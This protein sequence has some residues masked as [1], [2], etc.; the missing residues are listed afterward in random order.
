MNES[1]RALLGFLN[2]TFDKRRTGRIGTKFDRT[3]NSLIRERIRF[4]GLF[5]VGFEPVVYDRELRKYRLYSKDDDGRCYRVRCPHCGRLYVPNQWAHMEKHMLRKHG[6][7]NA[8]ARYLDIQVPDET[9]PQS[10]T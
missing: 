4:E 8:W 5:R 9:S 10:S 6:D 3:D 1:Q 2:Y 7:R